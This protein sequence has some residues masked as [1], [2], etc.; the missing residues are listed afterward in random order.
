[1][2][3][4]TG[5]CVQKRRDWLMDLKEHGADILVL[6]GRH[7]SYQRGKR[8]TNPGTSLIKIEGVDDTN[9]AKYVTN[10]LS[11]PVFGQGNVQINWNGV[12]TCFPASISERRSLSFIVYTQRLE[13][14][15][16]R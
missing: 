11:S 14:Q 8:N 7:L 13:D 9:A 6:R 5:D 15:R 4:E 16:S 1:M 12:L 3:R 10:S 2:A